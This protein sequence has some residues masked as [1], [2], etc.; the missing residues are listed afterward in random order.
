MSNR[1]VNRELCKE[2]SLSYEMYK[3][4]RTNAVISRD[5]IALP[6]TVIKWGSPTRRI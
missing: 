5:F 6:N 3:F 4:S 2:E 1:N